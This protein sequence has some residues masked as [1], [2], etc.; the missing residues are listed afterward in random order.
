VNHDSFLSP[1]LE[2]IRDLLATISLVAFDFDGV[3]TDNTVYVTQEGVE[4]VRCWRGDGIGLSRLRSIGVHTV[5]L[6]TEINPV[7]AVRAKKLKIE[8][9]QEL[10]DKAA[11]IKEF[12]QALGVSPKQAAFVGNDVNDIPAL[13][14]VGLP[15]AVSDAHTDILPYV[16]Y[17]TASKGGHGAVR[18]TCDLIYLARKGSL[19]NR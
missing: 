7:V 17:R 3:F 11:A 19:D 8:C 18:E 16:L 12:C 14:T 9:R 10:D 13:M 4:S 6:S 15:I 5:I 1:T 2:Q